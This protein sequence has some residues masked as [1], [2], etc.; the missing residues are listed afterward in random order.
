MY[1]TCYK[2]KDGKKHK[3]VKVKAQGTPDEI[4]EAADDKVCPVCGKVGMSVL[5]YELLGDIFYVKE[6]KDGTKK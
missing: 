6:K 4:F 5:D 2:D 3:Q 1:Y